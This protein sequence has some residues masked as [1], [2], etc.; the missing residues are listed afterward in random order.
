M[1]EIL[2]ILTDAVEN[3]AINLDALERALISRGQLNQG[4]IGVH[5]PIP[6]LIVQQRLNHLRSAISLLGEPQ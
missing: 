5:S 1:K 2:T 6:T 4:E 3:L